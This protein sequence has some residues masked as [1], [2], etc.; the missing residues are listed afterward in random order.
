MY[1]CFL[2][3]KDLHLKA[4]NERFSSAGWRCRQNLKY[5]NFTSSFGRLRQNKNSDPM[6]IHQG[7]HTHHTKLKHRRAL[8]YHNVKQWQSMTEST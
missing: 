1:F 6:K 2:D 5:E 8:H 3:T 7:Q 4:K